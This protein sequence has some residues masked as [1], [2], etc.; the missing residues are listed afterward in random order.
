[1]LSNVWIVWQTSS[2]TTLTNS[3]VPYAC[4]TSIIYCS[5]CAARIICA[6]FVL[7]TWL[8]WSRKLRRSR[9]APIDAQSKSLISL[10][11]H[12]RRRSRNT[13][14][15]KCQ[16]APTRT[17][18][19]LTTSPLH[20]RATL[21]FRSKALWVTMTSSAEN[22]NK[23]SNP[24]KISCTSLYRLVDRATRGNQT[25]MRASQSF[26]IVSRAHACL[27]K[28]WASAIQCSD[29]PPSITKTWALI[30]GTYWKRHHCA[31]R[32]SESYKN[33]IKGM[34]LASSKAL[35]RVILK[36]WLT[37]LHKCAIVSYSTPLR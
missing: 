14:N 35:L 32:P 8:N 15:H 19:S 31:V 7:M 37:L 26:R 11:W 1:M 13:V 20:P 4:A 24:H 2:N 16:W 34:T 28:M 10:M 17:W 33:R 29:Q 27:C 23:S 6:S 36:V 21:K 12:M 18:K 22:N 5:R 3:R 25:K 9:G 30:K